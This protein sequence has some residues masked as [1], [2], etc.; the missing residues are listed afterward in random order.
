MKTEVLCLV[1]PI[2]IGNTL[3]QSR[4]LKK[5]LSGVKLDPKGI[6]QTINVSGYVNGA[7]TVKLIENNSV[8]FQEKLIILK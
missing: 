1:V 7:Y 5:T 6:S 4:R 3:T 2:K 8:V